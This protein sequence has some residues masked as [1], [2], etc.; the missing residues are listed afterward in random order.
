MGRGRVLAVLALL[1]SAACTGSRQLGAFAPTP[2]GDTFTCLVQQLAARGYLVHDADREAG[3]I[4]AEKTRT[5]GFAALLVGEEFTEMVVN[6]IPVQQAAGSEIR[7]QVSRIRQESGK[8]RTG[9]GMQLSDDDE[10][11]AR[12]I[13]AACGE[14]VQVD[15]A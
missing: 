5:S 4:R 15:A 7:L 11:D 8:E 13:T 14:P 12:D 6:V 9:A 1:V 3:F 10:A 2:P